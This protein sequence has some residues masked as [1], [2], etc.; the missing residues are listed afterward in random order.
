VTRISCS[1]V[2]LIEGHER[3]ADRHENARARFLVKHT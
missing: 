3:I 1:I 2:T